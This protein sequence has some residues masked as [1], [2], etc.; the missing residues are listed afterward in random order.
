MKTSTICAAAACLALITG[1]ALAEGVPLITAASGKVTVSSDPQRGTVKQHPVAVDK[2]AFGANVVTVVVDGVTYRFAGNVVRPQLTPSQASAAA[3]L[4]PPLQAWTGTVGTP[5][6]P[7]YGTIV[8]V[9]DTKGDVGGT[10]HLPPSRVLTFDSGRAVMEE[11]DS[12][13]STFKF[14]FVDTNKQ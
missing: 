14:Q 5:G 6:Q 12:N 1:A 11:T 3:K 10:M 7:G 4:T 9:K 2:T 13:Q 8:L